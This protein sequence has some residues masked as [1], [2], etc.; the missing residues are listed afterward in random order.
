MAGEKKHFVTCGQMKILEKRADKTGLSYR[1]MMENAGSAAAEIIMAK[2][3]YR[4]LGDMERAREDIPAMVAEGAKGAEPFT[5]SLCATVF[6]GKGNNGGDG[7]VVARVLDEA[8]EFALEFCVSGILS[9]T[10][11]WYEQDSGMDINDFI[12]LM[13]QMLSEPM[14]LLNPENQS[15]LSN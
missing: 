5:D 6:C 11:M 1:Q 14:Q 9:C 8:G 13:L 15:E 2:T 10:R 7:F 3:A 4:S 12:A